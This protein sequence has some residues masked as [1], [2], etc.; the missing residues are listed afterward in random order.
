M[1]SRTGDFIRKILGKSRSKES[2]V[3]YFRYDPEA[4]KKLLERINQQGDLQ[5][6]EIPR[7]LVTL[8]EF[9]EGNHDSGSIGCNLNPPPPPQAF[10]DLFRSIREKAEVNDVR[11]MIIGQDEPGSWPFSD[12]IWLITSAMPDE[13]KNWLGDQFQADDLIL[14][15]EQDCR[16]LERYHIPQGMR[17]IGVWWD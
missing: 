9:F 5:D 1:S 4:L 15:F 7:P 16:K 11:V 14:G 17:A 6:Q 2:K 12:T 10:Y 8:E 13:V 3:D